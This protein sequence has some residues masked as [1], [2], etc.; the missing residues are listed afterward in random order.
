MILFCLLISFFLNLYLSL[1]KDPFSRKIVSTLGGIFIST[2]AYGF[3]ML[4]LIP[5]NMI[6]YMCMCLLPRK[7]CHYVAIFACGS[8][9]TIGNYIRQIVFDDAGYGI[10]TLLMITFVK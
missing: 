4:F 7:S 8:F 9:L 6:G 1:L 3:G 10:S 2:Y 5:Y